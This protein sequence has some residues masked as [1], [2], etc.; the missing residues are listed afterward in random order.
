M[1]TCSGFRA[2]YQAKN[3]SLQEPKFICENEAVFHDIPHATLQD[4]CE[5]IS[6]E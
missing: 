4:G 3:E 1:G 2:N 6:K 5:I